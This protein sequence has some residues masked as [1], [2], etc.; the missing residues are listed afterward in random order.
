VSTQH[1]SLAQNLPAGIRCGTSS[2][3]FPGWKGLVYREAYEKSRLAQAGLEAYARHPL[4]RSVGLDRTYYAALPREEFEKLARAVGEG[5]RFLVKAPSVYTRPSTPPERGSA[6]RR[7]ADN[8]LYLDA[9]HATRSFVEPFAEGL[10]EAAGPLVFQFSPIPR[11]KLGEAARFAE[12]LGVFLSA[13]P[14]GPLYAVEIRNPELLVPDYAEALESAGASHCFN[15]HPT[16]P[17]IARQREVLE[18]AGQGATVVRWMLGHGQPYQDAKSRYAPFDRIMDPDPE[19]RQAIAELCVDA[20]R[21][22][23]PAWVIVNNKAEGSAPE[24]VFKLSELMVR[25]VR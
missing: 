19:N 18:G 23:R 2:W 8:P 6:T 17:L 11:W 14:K 15:V 7:W 12:R 16:M 9:E 3:A 5:F 20:A 24:S 4:L 1:A 25:L 21:T 13:L 10:G 22:K